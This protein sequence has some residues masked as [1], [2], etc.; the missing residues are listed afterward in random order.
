VREDAVARQRGGA[1]RLTRTHA[2][3]QDFGIGLAG[4]FDELAGQLLLEGSPGQRRAGGEFVA[5][6]IGNISYGDGRAHS[7]IMQ[8]ML[9]KYN[10]ATQRENVRQRTTTARSADKY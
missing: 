5:R 10:L 4:K 3:D 6:L 8:L 7:I 1:R 9:L 2:G